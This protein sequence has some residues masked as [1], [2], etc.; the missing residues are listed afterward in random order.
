[1]AIVLFTCVKVFFFNLFL[2]VN[3]GTKS[4]W[5]SSY[6]WNIGGESNFKHTWRW[7]W[8]WACL[9]IFAWVLGWAGLPW[10]NS[11]ELTTAQIDCFQPCHWLPSCECQ[12]LSV[13]CSAEKPYSSS[14]RSS[15]GPRGSL[16]IYLSATLT[17]HFLSY[18][19][20]RRELPPTLNYNMLNLKAVTPKWAVGF[21][22]P[23]R[24]RR[25]SCQRKCCDCDSSDLLRWLDETVSTY[26]LPL[27]NNHWRYLA[28][29]RH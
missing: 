5:K 10:E 15:L 19:E 2:T 18:D 17:F 7:E 29:K 25:T 3:F 28:A 26:L 14:F 20:V 22:F 8:V 13:E 24:K 1:M 27:K 16:K 9:Y 12:Y 4:F 11:W 21:I 6:K 23:L